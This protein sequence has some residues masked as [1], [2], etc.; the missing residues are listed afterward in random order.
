MRKTQLSARFQKKMKKKTG[1]DQDFSENH[2]SENK[3]NKHVYENIKQKKCDSDADDQMESSDDLET[4]N[5][6]NNEYY[7]NFGVHDNDDIMM[8][9]SW[10]HFDS[11]EDG[12]INL[13]DYN[14]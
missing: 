14:T 5:R 1:E 8:N 7:D 6:W 10:N 11:D 4:V 9:E 12:S 2:D 13:L 3:W